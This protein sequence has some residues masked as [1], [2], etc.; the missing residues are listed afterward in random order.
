VTYRSSF[1]THLPVDRNNVVELAACGRARWK[2][3]NESFNTLK[4]KGYNL[5]HNFGHGQHHLS[6][7]LAILNLTAFAFHTVAELLVALWRNAL[8]QIGA[9][10]H[11]FSHLRAITAY[12]LFPSWSDLLQ[13]LAGAIPQPRP[14]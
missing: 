7:V 9:R 10:A 1:I 8:Q 2:I 5:E 6:A 4:T 11:F 3:E 14:P 13:T 12:I